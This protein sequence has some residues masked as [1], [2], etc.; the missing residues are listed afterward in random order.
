MN[1]ELNRDKLS[2]LLFNLYT[3]SGQRTGI[4]DAH[5]HVI[6]EYPKRHCAF[7][8]RIR[9]TAEGALRCRECDSYGMHKATKSGKTVVYRCHAGLL[10]VCSPI[11]E[12]EGITGFLMFGQV[13][14]DRETERQKEEAK[15]QCA[16]L[17]PEPAVFDRLFEGVRQISADYLDSVAD[18]M[19]AC[20]GYIRLE[21]LMKLRHEDLW[22]RMLHYIETRFDRPF[23]LSEMADEL[24]VSVST[25]CKTAQSRSG[26]TVGQLA[27][28]QRVQN[29]KRLLRDPNLAVSNVAA[30]VGI[31]DY[32]YFSRLFRKE[33]GLSPTAFRKEQAG[34]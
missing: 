22:G 8:A 32:S 9:S 18:I 12:E 24:S 7:C 21:Q 28:E 10:E 15:R 31:D 19:N 14:Y 5:F 2:R 4:F 34:F 3:V 27:A 29:A 17:I 33:T 11:L 26:K 30:L 1:T 25:L 6:M 20:V 23:T 16:G 13:L